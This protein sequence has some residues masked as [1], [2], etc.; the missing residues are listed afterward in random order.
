MKK[1]L[2]LFVLLLAVGFAS[3]KTVTLDGVDS[4]SLEGWTIYNSGYNPTFS[5]SEITS[6][7]DG[8]TAIKTSVSGNTVMYCDTKYIYKTFDVGTG[9]SDST[10]MDAYLEF[11]YDGTYYNFPFVMIQ[12]LDSNDNVLGSHTWYGK[13]VVGG[14]YQSYIAADPTSY[15]ELSSDKG[16]FNLDF[17]AF[18]GNIEYSKVRVYVMDYTC[19]GNNYVVFDKLSLNTHSNSHPP[20]EEVP[21]FG[22]I[23]GVLAL[24][25][26]VG[27]F[28][29]RR[30]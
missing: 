11:W 15:T 26:A 19:I 2:I 1:L 5:Y 22:T 28:L 13:G 14:L 12:L 24:L 16:Y 9:N 27:I 10:D 8:G 17:E 20:K 23:A 29:Y 7:Y 6:P 21:E 25:G 30:K 18:P 4:G 3:A